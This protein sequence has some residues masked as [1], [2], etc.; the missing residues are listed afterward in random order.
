MGQKYSK[1]SLRSTYLTR[2]GTTKPVETPAKIHRRPKCSR[3]PR[4]SQAADGESERTQ[5]R[6]TPLILT[7]FRT[8]ISDKRSTDGI[9]KHFSG[10]YQSRT[11][12]NRNVSRMN[13]VLSWGRG[14]LLLQAQQSPL[15]S[16]EGKIATGSVANSNYY[17]TQ[18]TRISHK[19]PYHHP[20]GT[21]GTIK[22][23]RHESRSIRQKDMAHCRSWTISTF[24]ESVDLCFHGVRWTER[25]HSLLSSLGASCQ[26]L[27]KNLVVVCRQNT[28][29]VA[30][31]RCNA[32]AS[33]ANN[34]FTP[35]NPSCLRMH[36]G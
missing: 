27:Q 31:E 7:R 5:V 29:E 26:F 34:T 20:Y 13:C 18:R 24:F 17:K 8:W 3:P 36:G 23:M 10:N 28:V 14:E 11:R 32:S 21:S 22:L 15:S 25:V 12:I 2:P 6:L 35:L 30:N 19:R 4:S 9:F 1:E 33:V 16:V